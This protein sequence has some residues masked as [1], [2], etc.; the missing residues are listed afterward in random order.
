MPIIQSKDEAKKL[1]CPF[2]SLARFSTAPMKTSP[3]NGQNEIGVMNGITNCMAD[4]CM[5]WLPDT[6]N[7]GHGICERLLIP[8][9]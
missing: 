4:K 3:I 6:E 7:K 8:G 1:V 5:A 2:M 9:A